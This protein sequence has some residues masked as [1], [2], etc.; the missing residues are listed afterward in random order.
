MHDTTVGKPN[1]ANDSAIVAK[2]SLLARQHDLAYFTAAK[3]TVERLALALLVL[4]CE[5]I[6]LH[7]R[8]ARIQ[9]NHG[10]TTGICSEGID[11]S[12]DYR[13]VRRP[14]RGIASCIGSANRMSTR[15]RHP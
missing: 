9:E 15:Q 1:D 4:D 5:T 13:Q 12:G 6:Q 3:T 14:T 11:A 10:L 8:A 2:L 7:S